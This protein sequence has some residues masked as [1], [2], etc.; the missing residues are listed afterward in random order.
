MGWGGGGWGG[1]GHGQASK[2][3]QGF[4]AG[5]GNYGWRLS[6]IPSPDHAYNVF[7]YWPEAYDTKAKVKL[8]K[9]FY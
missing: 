6:F 1:V 8:T 7:I 2:R 5:G 3:A 4:K 9:T